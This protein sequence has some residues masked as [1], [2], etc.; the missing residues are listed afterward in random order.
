MAWAR[1]GKLGSPLERA[2][3]LLLDNYIEDVP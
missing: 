2:F 1:D 3:R